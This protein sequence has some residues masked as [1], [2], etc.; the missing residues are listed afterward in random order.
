M[1][2]TCCFFL[3]F[4][5]G[6]SPLQGQ[7]LDRDKLGVKIQASLKDLSSRYG[8]THFKIIT[9]PQRLTPAYVSGFVT[10]P[11]SESP[12]K[13]ALAFIRHYQDIFSPD[14]SALKPL[15]TQTFKRGATVTFQQ[16]IQGIPVTGRYLNVFLDDE[17]R[18]TAIHS[19]IEPLE[20][21][22]DAGKLI[23]AE[24]VIGEYFK[25]E[26]ME[27]PNPLSFD[28]VATVILP[29]GSKGV[30]SYVIPVPTNPFTE[31]YF[32]YFDAHTGKLIWKENRIYR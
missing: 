24:V 27:L 32:Y 10:D 21:E 5:L 9:P 7:S 20:V 4:L 19:D 15:K 8:T 30:I 25:K 22:V 14:G 11:T 28:Q 12:E 26:S 6:A 31:N 1:K 2:I 3:I 18:I 16:Y 17:M 23:P 13:T 29:Q